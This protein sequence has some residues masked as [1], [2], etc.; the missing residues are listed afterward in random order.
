MH[1]VILD[2]AALVTLVAAI[3]AAATVDRLRTRTNTSQR[4]YAAGIGVCAASNFTIAIVAALISDR[5]D[6]LLAVTSAAILA[7]TVVR[8]VE[9]L[10][11]RF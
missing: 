3:A 1:M 11:I 9:V 5:T 6:Q 10:R 8:L 2:A 7:Y 4:V